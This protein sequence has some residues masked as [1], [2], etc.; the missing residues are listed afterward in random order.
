MWKS[1][2]LDPLRFVLEST[3]GPGFLRKKAYAKTPQP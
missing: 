1:G 3:P 2:L